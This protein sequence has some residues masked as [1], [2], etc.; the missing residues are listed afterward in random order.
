MK[1]KPTDWTA[2]AG[3]LFIV[4]GL[5]SFRPALASIFVGVVLFLGAL[6]YAWREVKHAEQEE[7]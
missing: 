3:L 6:A 4:I 2:L 7:N 1:L 5:F